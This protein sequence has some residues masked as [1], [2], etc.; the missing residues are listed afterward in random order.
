MVRLNV[1]MKRGGTLALEASGKCYTDR[2]GAGQQ[3]NTVD[4]L[5]L[6]WPKKKNSKK[7]YPVKPDLVADWS[8]VEQDYWDAMA[9]LAE[10]ASVEA[11]I[12]A[13]ESRSY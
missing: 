13:Y 12:D 6:Y 8:A 5:E 1:K 3:Y 2:D 11:A 4:D 9:E 7:L 10:D